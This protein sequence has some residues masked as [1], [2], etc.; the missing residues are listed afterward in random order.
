MQSTSRMEVER[1][2]RVEELSMRA[3]IR[4]ETFRTA[5]RNNAMEYDEAEAMD[6][7]ADGLS[8]SEFCVLVRERELGDHPDAELRQRFLSLDVSGSG[9]VSKAEYLRFSLRDS[10]S[11]SVTRVKEVFAAWD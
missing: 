8:Y 9:R 4:Q 1:V 2:E 3:P 6:D 5:M 10:L 7:A 11:R